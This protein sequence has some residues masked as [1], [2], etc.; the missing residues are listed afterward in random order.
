[1]EA[2][3]AGRTEAGAQLAGILSRYA[4]GLPAMLAAEPFPAGF[5]GSIAGLTSRAPARSSLRPAWSDPGTGAGRGGHNPLDVRW[6]SR[7]LRRA[8]RG[9]RGRGRGR[10]DCRHSLHQGGP[11]SDHRLVG[12]LKPT[13]RLVLGRTNGAIPAK[14]LQLVAEIY[15]ESRRRTVHRAWG[16]GILYRSCDAAIGAEDNIVDNQG[17]RLLARVLLTFVLA[18]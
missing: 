11:R 9:A 10:T 7:G 4:A 5:A 18:P 2:R 12:R 15:G 1:V 14:L 3:A 6:V 13:W 17:I 8:V 16:V